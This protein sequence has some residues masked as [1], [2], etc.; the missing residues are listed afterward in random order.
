MFGSSWDR[1]SFG[2]QGGEDGFPHVWGIIATGDV[3]HLIQDHLG[4]RGTPC[5]L[6]DTQPHDK[7]KEL[8]YLVP[9]LSVPSEW[10]WAGH[11]GLVSTGKI[12]GLAVLA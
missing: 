6:E 8:C 10:S 1:G 5:V 12:L 7:A 9:L 4:A 3:E 2:Q 11:V